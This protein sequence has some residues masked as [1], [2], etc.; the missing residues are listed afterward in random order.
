MNLRS[1]REKY[2]NSYIKQVLEFTNSLQN[3]IPFLHLPTPLILSKS[4]LVLNRLQKPYFGHRFV[5]SYRPVDHKSIS[6]AMCYL[7]AIVI[8]GLRLPKV[9]KNTINNVS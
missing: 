5:S 8:G 2:F 7:Q 3:P 6:Y 1:F 4:T 9:L